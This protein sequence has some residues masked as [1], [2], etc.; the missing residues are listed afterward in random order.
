MAGSTTEAVRGVAR[1]IRI[2]PA[3]VVLIGFVRDW[4]AADQD[5]SSKVG[6]EASVP[7]FE[8]HAVDSLE[9]SG[10]VGHNRPSVT[11]PGSRDEHIRDA[12]GR[13]AIQ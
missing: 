10:V 11:K 6:V 9:I 4:N 13:S 7:V 5:E 1:K 3:S 8:N 2:S 12:H